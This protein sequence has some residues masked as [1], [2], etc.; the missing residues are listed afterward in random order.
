[1]ITTEALSKT[2]AGLI[3]PNKT[4]V[5]E[6]EISKMFVSKLFKIF[7][8]VSL[9]SSPW[10]LGKKFRPSIFRAPHYWLEL[11]PPQDWKISWVTW[12]DPLQK[13]LR[14]RTVGQQYCTH[15]TCHPVVVNRKI[16]A[17]STSRIYPPHFIQVMKTWLPPRHP[18][19][20][21]G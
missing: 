14:G 8:L 5:A 19:M 11:Q 18:Q 4:V 7:I 6:S 15:P 1:M 16:M 12:M 10:P 17:I 13:T 9:L 3:L 2:Q 21:L 20:P